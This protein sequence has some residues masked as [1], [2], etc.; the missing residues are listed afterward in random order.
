M[1][2]KDF[3]EKR[4]W[5]Q[6]KKSIKGWFF[7]R[8]RFSRNILSLELIIMFLSTLESLLFFL[9]LSLL[10]TF[11]VNLKYSSKLKPQK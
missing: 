5:M 4:G 9:I 2:F 3:M 11:I 1:N 10:A 8:I 6:N 7:L